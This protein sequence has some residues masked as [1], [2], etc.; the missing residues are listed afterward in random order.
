MQMLVSPSRFTLLAL[1]AIALLGMLGCGKSSSN[2]TAPTTMEGVSFSASPNPIVT[3]DGSHLGLTKLSW[4]T[5]KTSQAE[6]HVGKPDGA[7]LCKGLASG[8]CDTAKWVT[9]GMSFFLQDS[10]AAAPSASSATLGSVKVV[11]Q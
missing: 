3:N 2:E 1:T 4:S 9:D 6:I 5:L 8:S 11:V 10:T 7:L